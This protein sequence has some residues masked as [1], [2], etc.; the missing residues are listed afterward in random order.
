MGRL[1]VGAGPTRGNGFAPCGPGCGGSGIRTHGALAS[2]TVFE[3]VR[4]G[5][6]R[7]PPVVIMGGKLTSSQTLRDSTGRQS[8][9]PNV[10]SG[11][12][13]LHRWLLGCGFRLSGLHVTQRNASVTDAGPGRV[14]QALLP[15]RTARAPQRGRMAGA[16]RCV[17]HEEN[18]R[19][20]DQNEQLDVPVWEPRRLAHQ[21]EALA[22]GTVDRHVARDGS[23]DGFVRAPRLRS[24]SGADGRVT[25]VGAPARTGRQRSEL[26]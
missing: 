21:H 17:D 26:I 5:R 14:L 16:R 1:G 13:L 19:G 12:A 24:L 2:T 25:D 18:I 23:R 15:R 4:F 8:P 6:S 3:T 10:S 7:I 11:A 22:V 20:S 9:S